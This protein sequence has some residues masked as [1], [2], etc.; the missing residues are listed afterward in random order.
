M[1][2]EEG[3]GRRRPSPRVYPMRPMLPRD[4]IETH[5]RERFAMALSEL[6]HEQSEV[7]LTVAHVIKRAGASRNTFYEVFTNKEA[8]LEFSRGWARERLLTAIGTA[9]EAD[10]EDEDRARAVIGALLEAATK[11][12]AP[13]ELCL[14]HSAADFE[15]REGVGDMATIEALARALSTVEDEQSIEVA[16][17]LLA[18]GILTVVALRLHRGELNEPAALAEELADLVALQRA[19]AWRG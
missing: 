16:S 6:V 13:V 1:A 18:A 5:R 9:A 7:E 10:G 3:S 4:F 17:E 14:I 15:A 11:L 2:T 19:R 8:C 12:P